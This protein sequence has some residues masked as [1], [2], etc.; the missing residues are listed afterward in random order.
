[1]NNL[2]NED[3]SLLFDYP[4]NFYNLNY[5]IDELP[6]DYL[7]II[8]YSITKENATK[9]IQALKLYHNIEE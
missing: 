2:F 8:A 4:V 6:E 1:M 3:L 5:I 9:L 7:K